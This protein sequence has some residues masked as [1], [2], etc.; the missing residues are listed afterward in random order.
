MLL[1]INQLLQ[2]KQNPYVNDW[3][4]P[5][6]LCLP[7]L[8]TVEAHGEQAEDQ[9]EVKEGAGA[10]DESAILNGTGSEEEEEMEVEEEVEEHAAPAQK[11]V[12]TQLWS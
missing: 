9:E 2:Y 10:V 8:Q 3:R 5:H 4:I 6:A 11:V 12:L 7:V 1:E